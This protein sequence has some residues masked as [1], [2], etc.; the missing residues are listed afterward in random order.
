MEGGEDKADEPRPRMKYTGQYIPIFWIYLDLLTPNGPT[1]DVY[2]KI[3]LFSLLYIFA[4]K[5]FCLS[6]SH[7][8]DSDPTPNG[9]T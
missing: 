5:S 7:D 2:P 9:H 3:E 4:I 1:M 8:S 6:T